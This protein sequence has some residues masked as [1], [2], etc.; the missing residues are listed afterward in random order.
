[1]KHKWRKPNAL[2]VATF[3]CTFGCE[4][5]DNLD[6]QC[7]MQ[8]VVA[9]SEATDSARCEQ[10]APKDFSKW[11]RITRRERAALDNRVVWWCTH[12]NEGPNGSMEKQCCGKAVYASGDNMRCAKHAP[13]GFLK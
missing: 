5:T 12:G 2:E 9:V 6:R 13:K 3:C 11:H 7:L 4:S 8:P 10:H 1:M